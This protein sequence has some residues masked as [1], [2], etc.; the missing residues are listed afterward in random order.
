[1]KYANL[2]MK[3]EGLNNL[4]DNMQLLAIENLYIKMGI[5]LDDIVYI[6]YYDLSTYNGD[7][8]ILPINFPFYGYRNDL[9]ITVFSTK[10]I[11]VFL[12]LSIMDTTLSEKEVLY[13]KQFEPIGCRDEHTLIGLKKYGISSYLNGCLTATFPLIEKKIDNDG[14]IFLVDCDDF[15]YNNIP[16]SILDE[17]EVV[18]QMVYNVQNPEEY[19]RMLYKKYCDEAKLIITTRLHCAIPCLAA[20]I[21]V[22]LMKEDY[23]FRFPWLNKLM[24]I[25]TK[26]NIDDID[27]NTLPVYYEELKQK[28]TDNAITQIKTKFAQYSSPYEISAFFE[29][30][31]NEYHDAV[32]H[33]SA[34]RKFIEKNWKKDSNIKYSFWGVTQPAALIFNYI[35][36]NYP[37]AEL[38]FVYDKY[39]KTIFCGCETRKPTKESLNNGIFTFITSASAYQEAEQ[40]YKIL[41]K[42]N[43][44][45]C[46]GD[47]I[48]KSEDK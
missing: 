36:N 42:D 7:Y 35:Q 8:V 20:G 32:E 19:T 16:K 5:D 39:K 48:L 21:P 23:S 12:G 22:V 13:L 38:K 33:Y 24:K 18:T 37:N 15:C 28:I 4:G 11:P 44:Y 47:K 45:Q 30:K 6:D 25:Y 10:I 34:A 17:A 26:E 2:R 43:Y 14:K 46:S 29:D 9:D 31:D 27:F 1:M 40:L 3:R 41:G